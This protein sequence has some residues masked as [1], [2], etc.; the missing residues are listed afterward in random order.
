MR[1][2]IALHQHQHFNHAAKACFVSQSTLSSA[3]AKLEQQLNCQLIER[4]NKSFLFT[5]QGNEFVERSRELLLSAQDLVKFAEQQNQELSGRYNIGCI[6]SIA[7]YLLTELVPACQRELPQLRAYF[8][9]DTTENLLAMLK[10]GELDMAILALP[11]QHA[12]LTVKEVGRDKLFAAGHQQVMNEFIKEHDFQSLPAQSV[13]LLSNEHCLTEHAL[14]ACKQLDVAKVN[15][16]SATSLTTLVQMTA[17]HQG[18]TILP[19]MAIKNG[20]AEAAGLV[21]YQLPGNAARTIALTWR[22][23]SACHQLY[24]QF[25]RLL[26]KILN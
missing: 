22:T 2:L 11:T 5:S 1:Y 23:T 17:Y 10:N 13:F 25:S 24:Q 4:D 3:I 9:E 15:H 7:P 6:P 20:V 12:G 19:E 14:S 21:A 16:F 18:F 8:V 26:A